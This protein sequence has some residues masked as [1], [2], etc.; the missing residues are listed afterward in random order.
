MEEYLKLYE[1]NKELDSK[2]MNKYINND[3]FQNAVQNY[4]FLLNYTNFQTLNITY[5]QKYLSTQNF[6]STPIS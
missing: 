2:F 5:L 3:N 4:T 1:R 6:T